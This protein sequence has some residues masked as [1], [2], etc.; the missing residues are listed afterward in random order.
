MKSAHEEKISFSPAS[1]SDEY[2]L[3]WLVSRVGDARDYHLLGRH[4]QIRVLHHS[5]DH[6]HMALRHGV[7]QGLYL[8][9]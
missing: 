3:G 9:A 7:R 4:P 8:G 6:Q 1:G 5:H 2:L